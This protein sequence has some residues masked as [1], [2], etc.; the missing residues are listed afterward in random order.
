MAV[1]PIFVVASGTWSDYGLSLVLILGTWLCLFKGELAGGA[2]LTGLAVGARISNCVWILPFILLVQ[3]RHGSVRALG[4]MIAASVAGWLAIFP[5]MAQIGFNLAGARGSEAQ[6][7]LGCI[8]TSISKIA[9]FIGLPTILVTI[10][11]C[12][13]AEYRKTLS[14]MKNYLE[15]PAAL[16]AEFVTFTYLPSDPGY[17]I[18]TLPVLALLLPKPKRESM[19][20]LQVAVVFLMNFIVLDF[21]NKI[22]SKF[23]LSHGYYVGEFTC[24]DNKTAL[25]KLRFSIP[26]AP[27]NGFYYPIGDWTGR[28]N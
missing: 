28:E 5:S 6:P 16:I 22:P 24:N 19:I 7:I 2:A 4:Y 12:R 15:L 11:A 17:I 10:A 9:G 23:H 20:F 8:K 26:R 13:S 1:H 18:T 27:N 21:Q 3:R 25:E 14:N